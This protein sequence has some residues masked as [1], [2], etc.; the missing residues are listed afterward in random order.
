MDLPNN[1]V[2]LYPTAIHKDDDLY[3]TGAHMVEAL[4]DEVAKQGLMTNGLSFSF[5]MLI[6]GLSKG[7]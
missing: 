4:R 5:D 2:M 1:V 6:Y 7:Q 3:T